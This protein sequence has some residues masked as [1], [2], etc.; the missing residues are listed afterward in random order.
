MFGGELAG[1]APAQRFGHKI[2][3]QVI[4]PGIVHVAVQVDTAVGHFEG[5]GG[6]RLLPAE[7]SGHCE[8]ISGDDFF[9]VDVV[10][11][12]KNKGTGLLIDQHPVG[13]GFEENAS[14]CVHQSEVSGKVQVHG[15]PGP[16][17]ERDL[18]V[19]FRQSVEEGVILRDS[20]EKSLIECLL[21][22]DPKLDRVRDRG[23]LKFG[24]K[25]GQAQPARTVDV[26]G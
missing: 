19:I 1:A 11:F 25:S 22:G 21:T 8:F 17:E 14:L 10:A 16:G 4:V 12:R 15:L 20:P 5:T 13:D 23:F 3:C 26:A 6:L 7:S 2:H 9:D 18:L 24:K